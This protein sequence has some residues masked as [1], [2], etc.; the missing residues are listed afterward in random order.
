MPVIIDESPPTERLRA[1]HR[2]ARSNAPPTLDHSRDACLTIG[3]VNNM[4]DSALESTEQQFLML[5]DKAAKDFVVRIKLFSINAVPRGERARQH[6]FAHYSDIQDLQ[7][8]G[9][10]GLI[11]TGTEPRAAELVDEPYWTELTR[12]FDWAQ[13]NTTTTVFSCLAAHAAVLHL[14][15]IKR[16]PLPEKRFGVFWHE[17]H[18]DHFLLKGTP[19]RIATPHSR[20][21]ELPAAAL[22]SAGYGIITASPDAGVDAFVRQGKSLFVFF[23]GHPEYEAETLRREYR[24]DIG[25]FLR[26]ERSRYPGLPSHYFDQ[27]TTQLLQEFRLR[28]ESERREE[29][30]LEFPAAP[31]PPDIADAWRAPAVRSYRNWLAY[32]AAHRKKAENRRSRALSPAPAA[33]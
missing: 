24:R 20:W 5:L 12:L 17:K 28:A 1:T 31:M 10:D 21:N 9:L 16:M 6:L 18:S 11:V 27:A 26:G 13:E 19:R 3:L 33:P 29:L 25:Q 23:Q 14:H 4:P 32:M 30:L 2:I 8:G 22:A 7:G 15:G